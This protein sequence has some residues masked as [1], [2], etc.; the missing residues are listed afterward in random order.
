ME[1]PTIEKQT[2][3]YLFDL[4]NTALENGFK[5]DDSWE[6]ILGTEAQ[7]ARIQKDYYPAV[8]TKVFPEIVLPVF[9][10][11]KSRLNLALNKEEQSRDVKAILKDKLN[12]VIAFNPKRQRR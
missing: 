10:T 8:A 2:R 4:M 6:L 5:A 9:Y 1:N 3:M 11:I 12:Y 7:K